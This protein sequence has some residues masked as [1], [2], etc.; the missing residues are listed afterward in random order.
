MLKH[1][2]DQ[3]EKQVQSVRVEEALGKFLGP[4]L[5]ELNRQIDRRLVGTFLGSLMAKL[6][7]RHRHNGLLLSCMRPGNV[8]WCC[9]IRAC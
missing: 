9:G 8:R 6:C 7:H 2:Q 1:T 4:L 3:D 5:R